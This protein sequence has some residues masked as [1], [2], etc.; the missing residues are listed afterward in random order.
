MKELVTKPFYTNP[1]LLPSYQI[2]KIYKHFQNKNLVKA[3]KFVLNASQL[4]QLQLHLSLT[5]HVF[6]RKKKLEN[7]LYLEEVRVDEIRPTEISHI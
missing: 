7:R 2:P 4:S 3:H 6:N 5:L 1:S